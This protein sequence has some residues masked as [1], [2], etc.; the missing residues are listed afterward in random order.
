LFAE[1]TEGILKAN[2]K[3]EGLGTLLKRF[4]K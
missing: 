1:D 2:C 3:S 4:G